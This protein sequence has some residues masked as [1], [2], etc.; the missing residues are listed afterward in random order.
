MYYMRASNNNMTMQRNVLMM[1][2]KNR[3]EYSL[4]KLFLFVYYRFVFSE[5]R[6]NKFLTLQL[7]FRVPNELDS[8]I[9][10]FAR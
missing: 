5:G 7:S 3:S 1:T 6:A 9:V 8:F 4:T 2:T 10:H